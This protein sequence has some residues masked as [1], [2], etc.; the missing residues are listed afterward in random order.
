MTTAFDGFRRLVSERD[1]N[2]RPFDFSRAVF[3]DV[4]R[5]IEGHPDLVIVNAFI[6]PP[7]SASQL[8]AAEKKLGC[9]LP[10]DVKRFYSICNGLSLVWADRKES[11][12]SLLKPG[13]KDQLLNKPARFDHAAGRVALQPLEAIVAA[14]KKPLPAGWLALDQSVPSRK[15]LTPAATVFDHVDVQRALWFVASEDGVELCFG[16][17]KLNLTY[18]PRIDLSTYLHLTFAL[19][20]AHCRFRW[21]SGSPRDARTQLE[22]PDLSLEQVLSTIRQDVHYPPEQQVN[23]FFNEGRE[24]HVHGKHAASAKA[25]QKVIDADVLHAEARW[26][27]AMDLIALKRK[28]DALALLEGFPP[29]AAGGRDLLYDGAFVL[30][31]AGATDLAVSAVMSAVASWPDFADGWHLLGWLLRPEPTALPFLEHARSLGIEDPALDKEIEA[32]RKKARK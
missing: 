10:D 29:G 27:L 11:A 9:E 8:K 3:D 14:I 18:A 4:V 13:R 2:R 24:Q 25:L 20:G 16:Q 28:K 17:E 12:F 30:M 19:R 15:V 31:E 5:E 7:V 21:L 23:E 26:M 32:L 6:A 22:V 1:A